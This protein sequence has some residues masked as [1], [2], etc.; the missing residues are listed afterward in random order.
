MDAKDH[1]NAA[2]FAAAPAPAAA[3]KYP[4]K[5]ENIFVNPR[6]AEKLEPTYNAF[7]SRGDDK[8]A[9][10]QMIGLVVYDIPGK[11]FSGGLSHGEFPPTKEGLR[12]Y[13]NRYIRP[14]ARK[15]RAATALHFI[16]IVEPDV[17]GNLITTKDQAFVQNVA[18]FYE[19]GTAYA[20][21]TLQFRNV[22]LYI[23]VAN[24]GWLGWDATLEPTARKLAQIMR[25]AQKAADG[26][27]RKKGKTATPVKIRGFS[28]N[29]SNF[30]P[31]NADRDEPYTQGSRSWGESHY[32]DAL[33]PHLRNAKLP[34]HFIVDQ[35]RVD[36]PGARQKWEE[37]ANVYPAKFGMRPGT[38]VNN[39]FV[40][41]IV[42]VKPPGESDGNGIATGHPRAPPA[43]VWFPEYVEMLVKN[44]KF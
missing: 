25:R 27:A 32:I 36:L 43:G 18:P 41:S 20:I 38:A 44:S 23:D 42:W 39:T 14:L 24:G 3:P 13:K 22:R 28:T 40:D 4:W 2:Q 6:W 17:M 15:V 9:A 5:G 16:I 21:K 29:V 31:F 12:G 11:D 34:L 7:K 8:N 37:F 10:K 35:S 30:N 1:L 33:V 26:A 19:R